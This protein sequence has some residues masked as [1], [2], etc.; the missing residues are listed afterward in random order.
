MEKT[1]KGDR[2]KRRVVRGPRLGRGL[3]F[4][5]A[6]SSQGWRRPGVSVGQNL[7]EYVSYSF[8]LTGAETKTEEPEEESRL[9]QPQKE[10]F[11]DGQNG[12]QA[13]LKVLLNTR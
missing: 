6:G 9:V 8:V 11:R 10:P 4:S 12:S 3:S 2:E 5:D 1:Q 13:A 7:K